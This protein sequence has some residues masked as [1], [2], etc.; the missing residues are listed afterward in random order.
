MHI[1]IYIYSNSGNS[2]IS[3]GTEVMQLYEISLYILNFDIWVIFEFIFHWFH[4]YYINAYK[5]FK[6]VKFLIFGE[7]DV[8]LLTWTLLI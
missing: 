1:N 4:E 3:F 5:Y 2:N 6:F 8:I 7:I